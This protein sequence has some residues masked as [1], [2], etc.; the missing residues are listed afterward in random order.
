MVRARK[1]TAKA[2]TRRERVESKEKAIVSAA[3][4]MFADVGFSKTTISDIATEAGVAEGTVYLY[5]SNKE[6]LALGVLAQYYEK[7]TDGARRGVGKFKSTKQKLTFLAEHHLNSIVKERRLLELLLNV[8]RELE[9]Y[10][11][12]HVYK[13]NRAYVAVFDSVINEGVARGD[14][15]DA[16][17]PWIYRDIFY[18]GLDYSMRTMAIKKRK[19]GVHDVVTG[20]VSMVMKDRDNV[21]KFTQSP[22]IS[23][24]MLRMEHA[25]SRLEKLD[26]AKARQKRG[27]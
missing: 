1:S 13:M 11:N 6:A 20:L 16:V 19:S 8:D 4:E 25:V 27:K 9:N 15:S 5:F 14:V 10:S 7:L 2:A 17:A 3:Y 21:S 22:E 12:T 26:S 18:G 24:I 23:G